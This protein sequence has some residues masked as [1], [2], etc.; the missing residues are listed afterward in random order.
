MYCLLA[1]GAVPGCGSKARACRDSQQAYLLTPVRPAWVLRPTSSSRGRKADM[2]SQQ[3]PDPI[4]SFTD[5]T[6][7]GVGNKLKYGVEGEYIV[8]EV[9]PGSERGCTS[10]T[11]SLTHSLLGDLR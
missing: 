5:I 11:G 3:F 1:M 10:V 9:R 7:L 4:C 8:S 6:S 2:C